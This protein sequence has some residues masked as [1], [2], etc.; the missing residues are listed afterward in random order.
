MS[1]ITSDTKRR[2]SKPTGI[3]RPTKA[4][5]LGR[6]ASPLVLGAAL[7]L[8][9]GGHVLAQTVELVVVDVKPVALGLQASK[10]IGM[11]VRNAAGE[12]VGTIDDLVIVPGARIMAILQVGGFL[13]LG[14]HLVVVPFES[15]AMTAG[16]TRASL[17]GGTK[18]ALRKLPEFQYGKK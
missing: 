7:A 4:G 3:D 1:T 5:V 2:S 17:P 10:L 12:K 14:G 6:L 11:E 18:E 9:S 15:L 13:G 8:L 16:G